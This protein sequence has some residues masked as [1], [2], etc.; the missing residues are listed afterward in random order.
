[1]LPVIPVASRENTFS[2]EPKI[3]TA[4]E[5]TSRN[6][7]EILLR[8][9]PFLVTRC[10]SDLRYIFVSEACARMFGHRPEELVGKRIVEVIGEKAFRTIL[11]HIDAVLSG[12]R[13]EYE[14]EVP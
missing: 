10:S 12:Q 6:D 7:A 1:M 8:N 5:L 11:P 14:A 4:A 9:T 2:S 13:V 3:A